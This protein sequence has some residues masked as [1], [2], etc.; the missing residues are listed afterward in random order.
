M[1]VIEKITNARLSRRDLFKAAGA[2]AL[3]VAAIQ[4]PIV[5][6]F[7]RSRDNSPER[8]GEGSIFQPRADQRQRV[9]ARWKELDKR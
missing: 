6:A 1:N 3:G 9:W 4:A 7:K 8:F 5:G 2:V